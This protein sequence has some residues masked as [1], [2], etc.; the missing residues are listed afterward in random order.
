MRVAYVCTNYNNSNDTVAAVHSLRVGDGAECPVVVVDNA[1]EMAERE[2]LRVLSEGDKNVHVIELETNVGYFS[3]LNVGLKVARELIPDADVIVA[4][5]NDLLFP[6]DFAA[7]IDAISDRFESYA[8]VSPDIVTIDGQHQNPHVISGISSVREIMYD[9]F[10]S[11]YVLALAMTKISAVL[12]RFVRRGDED[13]HG[14]GMEITQGHGSCYLLGHRFFRDF[15]EFWAPT[16]L[17]GEEFFLSLQLERQGQK[18][19]YDPAVKVT[20]V[21]HAAVG[22]MPSRTRWEMSQTAHRIY[23]ANNP[24]RKSKP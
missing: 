13:Q 11:N 4:G 7:S 23:R 5:N 21:W 6:V 3:G 20:H 12:G 15:G 17:F 8:V 9:I 1:S 10:Y 22:K 19:F 18:V 2:K 16:F 14:T 24:I